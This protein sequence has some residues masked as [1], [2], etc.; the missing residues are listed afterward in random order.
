ME[1]EE[2][3]KI[4]FDSDNRRIDEEDCSP[5]SPLRLKIQKMMPQ[6]DF[7]NP[8]KGTANTTKVGSSI[9]AIENQFDLINMP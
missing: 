2:N 1:E 8:L 4:I 5:T 7:I 6:M 9:T 3:P